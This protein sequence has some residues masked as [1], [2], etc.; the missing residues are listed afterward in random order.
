MEPEKL[1]DG[2]I[3]VVSK[4]CAHNS[5]TKRPSYGVAGS[6]KAEYCSQHASDGMIDVVRKRCAHNSCTKH[7]SYGVAGSRK[8]EYCSQG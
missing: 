5:C 7:S 2:M 6:R 3:N 4:S 1:K 8:A